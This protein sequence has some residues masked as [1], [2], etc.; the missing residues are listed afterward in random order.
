MHRMITVTF[1]TTGNT[2]REESAKQD[3]QPILGVH[4]TLQTNASQGKEKER[5]QQ[6]NRTYG[7]KKG[8]ERDGANQGKCKYRLYVDLDSNTAND[9]QDSQEIHIPT[10]Y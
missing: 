9:L 10:G 6:R 1:S 2:R 8:Q 3:H 4:K 5:E 7:R